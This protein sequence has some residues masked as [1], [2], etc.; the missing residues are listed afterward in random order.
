MFTSLESEGSS[1]SLSPWNLTGAERVC[2]C[3]CCAV[4]VH[5][6]S[7][8]E[9]GSRARRQQ[10]EAHWRSRSTSWSRLLSKRTTCSS[11]RHQQFRSIA[12]SSVSTAPSWCESCPQ[13]SMR[14]ACTANASRPLFQSAATSSESRGH[15]T[16]TASRHARLRN[17]S[18]AH[19][20]GFLF[21]LELGLGFA[22]AVGG[23][24]G[25]RRIIFTEFSPD[26]FTQSSSWPSQVPTETLP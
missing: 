24:A 26:G 13:R 1:S 5:L 14:H 4:R 7:K 3:T 22:I 9:T 16:C 2:T 8:Q 25:T 21:E 12:A 6:H 18:S 15:S 11:A 17:C 20:G 10:L 23:S 19:T